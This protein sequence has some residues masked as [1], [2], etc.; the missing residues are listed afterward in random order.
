MTFGQIAQ[1][2]H[3]SEDAQQSADLKIERICRDSRELSPNCLFI[4]LRGTKFDGHAFLD[5]VTSQ[6]SCVAIIYERGHFNP[7]GHIPS[8]AVDDTEKA[9]RMLA[10][11]WRETA[12][13]RGVKIITVAGSVGKTTCKELMPV[14][15]NVEHPDRIVHTHGSQNGFAGIPETIFKIDNQTRAAVIEVGI[16]SPGAMQQHMEM[17]RQILAY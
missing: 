3:R 1:S 10:K 9:Y 11:A 5:T 7:D 4:A 2:V 15:L 16:D 14:I 13:Q 12:Q 8:I 6:K 17:L